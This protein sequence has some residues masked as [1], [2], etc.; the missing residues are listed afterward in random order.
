MSNANFL[1]NCVVSGHTDIVQKKKR[2]QTLFGEQ[3]DQIKK[4]YYKNIYCSHGRSASGTQYLRIC[5]RSL[6]TDTHIFSL[7]SV[8]NGVRLPVILTVCAR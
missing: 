1:Q 4:N 6:T 8:E 7:E 2:R 5:A 3:K